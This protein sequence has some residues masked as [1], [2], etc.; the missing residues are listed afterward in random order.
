MLKYHSHY[1]CAFAFSWPFD[2]K[3]L[4]IIYQFSDTNARVNGSLIYNLFIFQ[5]P[6]LESEGAN[7]S[8]SVAMR[9][10]CFCNHRSEHIGCLERHQVVC[11]EMI[12]RDLGIY[13]RAF[14]CLCIDRITSNRTWH[15]LDCDA[16]KTTTAPPPTTTMTTTASTTAAVTPAATP[17]DECADFQL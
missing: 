7:I 1:T 8:I 9:F 6:C 12:T 5:Q 10:N 13:C 17:E 4:L 14:F 15:C 3:S 11:P 16:S 2:A